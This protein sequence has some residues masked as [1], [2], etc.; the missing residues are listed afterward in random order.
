MTTTVGDRGQ[1]DTTRVARVDPRLRWGQANVQRNGAGQ[2]PLLGRSVEV[3]SDVSQ[4]TGVELFAGAGGLAL[5]A[6]KA[7]FMSLATLEWNRWACDT[8][9]ENKAA[10]HELVRDW[11]VYQGD[12]RDFDWSQIDGD[13]DLV[14]GGPPCQPFSA[15]GRGRSVDDKR[16][17]FPT[18]AEVLAELRPKA[19]LIE[20]VRG[21]TRAAFA[22]YYEYVL[23]R[24]ATPELKVKRRETW[25]DHLLRLRKATAR[26]TLHYN[27]FPILLDAADFGVPQQRHRVFMVGFRSDL[28]V[29]WAFPEPAHS[30]EALVRDQWVT[31]E[32]WDRHGVAKS[33]RPARPSDALIARAAR[34]DEGE[35]PWATLRDALRGLPDPQT[36]A[37][38]DWRNHDFQPG[39]RSYKGHTG[40]VLDL[41]AKT[42]KA[43]AH[44]VPGGENMI[45]FHDDSVRYL[46]V[47]ESARVQTFPDDYELHGAWGEAMR[48][49]G[50]AVP[51]DL[52]EVVARQV[53][54]G[55]QSVSKE[56]KR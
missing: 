11:H 29:E 46:T 53:R 52:A 44:G 25:F 51:V 4:L 33:K 41:P 40:S 32:Y 20:N 30:L 34:L 7:G 45:R 26:N 3:F 35:R 49:L 39:A 56:G 2:T 27:V 38:A 55:L 19:F 54:L 22:D 13:V 15:G 6:Q 43:G 47:R 24:L 12:V 5:G 23:R 36:K 1:K 9:R 31:G 16:D 50:N 48:Q 18:T 17:M 14:S 21:L 28:G 42:L 8:I 37:A 10:G